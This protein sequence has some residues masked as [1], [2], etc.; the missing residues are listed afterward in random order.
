MNIMFRKQP[1]KPQNRI[2]SL[3]GAGTK[4][5]GNVS[6]SGGL[7]VDGEVVGNVTAVSDQPSTLVLSEQA[8]I[9]GEISVSH[10]VVNG[11]IAG[12]VYVDSSNF[13]RVA[14]SKGTCTTIRWRCT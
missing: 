3:I 13:S 10:L 12:P 4:I 9:E 6:F 8:R 11:E 5:E 1:S 7:R 2:D 14:G